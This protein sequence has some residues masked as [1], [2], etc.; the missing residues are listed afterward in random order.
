MPF[1]N[2]FFTNCYS[3]FPDRFKTNGFNVILNSQGKLFSAET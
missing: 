1:N 2:C 3:I